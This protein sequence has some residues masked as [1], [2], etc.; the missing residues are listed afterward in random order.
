MESPEVIEDDID[1]Q[2]IERVAAIDVAKATGMVC[3]RVPNDDEP[4]KRITSVWKVGATTNS[5]IELGDYLRCEQI[6]RVTL[7]STSDYWRPFFYLFE[8]AGLQPVL[9]NARE[10]KNVPGR[11]KTDKLDAIW[12]ARLTEKGM[13]NASFVPPAPIRQLRDYTRLRMDMVRERTRYW[14]RLEKLLEDA[15]IKVSSV[16]SRMTTVSV[17]RM[18]DALIAG[19]RSPK[20]LADLACGTMRKK[21]PELIEAL[22]GQF[23]A[24]HGEIAGI[25]LEQIDHL[26]ASIDHLTVRIDEMISQMPAAQGVSPDGTTG[27]GAGLEAG[28][29][30]LPAVDR[31]DEITGIGRAAAQTIIAEIGLDMTRFPTAGNLVSW[32]KF[33]PRTIQSGTKHATGKAGKGNPYLKGIVGEAAASTRTT[34][35]F[36]GARYRRLVKRMGK[37]KAIVAIARSILI[38]VWQLLADPDRRF[39]DLGGD[40]YVMKTN[41]D[42]QAR[43]HIRQLKALGYEVNI[44]PAA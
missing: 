7:E 13:L 39:A 38:I 35:S 17:R 41:T 10:V 37:K 9:V 42:K 14:Q 32:A 1:E 11:P 5:I 24:H 4:G 16:A 6:R 18:L 23:D 29:P 15:L 8:A 34:D 21:R 12:L 19:Q 3:T 27:P 25:M 22:T 26:T 28:A 2:I 30:V 40:Y 44:V 33:T 20:V 36:L 43:N 31:L